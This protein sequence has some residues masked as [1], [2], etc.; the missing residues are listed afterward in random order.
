MMILLF[1][2]C[3]AWWYLDPVGFSHNAVFS[4]LRQLGLHFPGYQQ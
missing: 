3:V 1:I 2:T 4:Y